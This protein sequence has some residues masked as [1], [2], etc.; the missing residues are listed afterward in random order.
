MVE[1]QELVQNR[2]PETLLC[3]YA[4]AQ[5]MYNTPKSF[6]REILKV[7]E[8]PGIISF[9]G[10]LPN[11]DLIDVGG[12]AQAA[13]AVFREDGR[14]A[15]QYSTTEGYLPLRRFIADRYKKRLGL[16]IPP[17]E[18]LITNGSQQCLDLVGKI[19]I[20]RGDRVAIERPGY[21]GAIQVFSLYEPVF[22]PVELNSEGPDLA[23]FEAAMAGNAAKI[24][25]CI[26]NSQ[27][28]SGITYSAERRKECADILAGTRTLVV[29][30]DAYGELQFSGR[31]LPPFKKYLPDQTILTG[32]FSKIFA[33]GMRLGWVCAP[34]AIM[35]Q[36]VV[37]KQASDLHSNYLSQRIASRYLAD[38][39]IDAH[40]RKIQVTYKEQRDHMI[41]AMQ[42]EMPDGVSWTNPH[43]GMFV[44]VTLPAG[45]S[46][47]EVFSDALKE[48]VA[49]LPGIPFY[50]D[51]G[52]TD[53]LRL[54][55][56]NS[57]ADRIAEGIHRLGQVI[58]SRIR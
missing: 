14:T 50:V 47:M 34:P 6:I 5:R 16:D 33:P 26:P 3:T 8:N 39:D 36:L 12:I 49:V 58:R 48:K 9:A 57:N 40:I 25:Y 30:D 18:I 2:D 44:W 24:F 21:L 7:T 17:D 31:S 11:P 32:S 41:A 29:E 19:L 1:K 56:S 20:D 15:L 37:A 43:G 27:N 38:N 13:V 46:S 45:C 54:N 51:G 22:V 4:F 53:T 10:G 52:G 55:F 23:A 28:P 35:D 42:Q